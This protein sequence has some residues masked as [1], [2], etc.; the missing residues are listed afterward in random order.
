MRRKMAWRSA[1]PCCSIVPNLV[2]VASNAMEWVFVLALW[3]GLGRALFNNS[4]PLAGSPPPPLDSPPPSSS[5]WAKSFSGPLANQQFSLEP[6]API[7]NHFRPKTFF[8]AFGASKT[9]APPGVPWGRSPGNWVGTPTASS[10][11]QSSASKAHALAG[12]SQ[13]ERMRP[14]H[15]I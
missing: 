10:V 13:G 3:G 12:L 11:L 7:A 9:S 15:E 4:G 2:R 14:L 1:A 5:D 8:G 6:S